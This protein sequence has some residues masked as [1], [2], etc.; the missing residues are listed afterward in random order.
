[1][2]GNVLDLLLTNVPDKIGEVKDVGRL[3]K[4]DHSMIQASIAINRE[5]SKTTERVPNW[6]RADWGAMRDR[7]SGRDWE[8]KLGTETVDQAWCT[9]RDTQ[10]G[11]VEENVLF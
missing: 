11:L 3:G 7:L 2:R 5:E 4:R 1:V 10:L 6:G 8:E 9:P